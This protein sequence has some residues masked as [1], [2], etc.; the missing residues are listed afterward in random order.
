[1]PPGRSPQLS[2]RWL[3]QDEVVRLLEAAGADLH[4]YRTALAAPQQPALVNA[5]L[6]ALRRFYAWVVAQV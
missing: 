6:T 5:A 1:L 2:E 3:A 4:P